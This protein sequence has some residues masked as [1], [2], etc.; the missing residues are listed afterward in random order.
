MAGTYICSRSLID[1][2]DPHPLSLPTPSTLCLDRP[3][4]SLDLPHACLP[5][6]AHPGQMA[7]TII[8]VAIGAILYLTPEPPDIVSTQT[9]ANKRPPVPCYAFA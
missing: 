8:F 9:S 7:P 5:S 3:H 4:F 1:G 2:A 6:Y